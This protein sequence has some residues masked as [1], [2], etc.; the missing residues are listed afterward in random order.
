MGL[1]FWEESL[2]GVFLVLFVPSRC[3]GMMQMGCKHLH[4]QCWEFSQGPLLWS[5][6]DNFQAGG[7]SITNI[8]RGK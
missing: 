1:N 5:S 2:P 7:L 8:S 6:I 4:R 3:T